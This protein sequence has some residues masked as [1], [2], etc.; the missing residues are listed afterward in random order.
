MVGKELP[1]HR[2]LVPVP[3][4]AEPGDKFGVSFRLCHQSRYDLEPLTSPL[5]ALVSPTAR[6][7]FWNLRQQDDLEGER[8]LELNSESQ[9]SHSATGWF[10][11]TYRVSLSLGFF[12]C[13]MGTNEC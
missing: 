13:K 9:L 6:W 12:T 8:S 11:A 1:A 2:S 3:G 10:G 5:W 4:C 7:V